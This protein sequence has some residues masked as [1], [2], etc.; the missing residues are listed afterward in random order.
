MI[1]L[2]AYRRPGLCYVAVQHGTYRYGFEESKRWPG[3]LDKLREFLA[4][5]PVICFDNL[6]DLGFPISVA[7]RMGPQP[8]FP[9]NPSPDDLLYLV[10]TRNL[11]ILTDWRLDIL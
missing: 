1:Y 2:D 9:P 5:R 4:G 11:D 3:G 10:K 6:P 8:A 7:R